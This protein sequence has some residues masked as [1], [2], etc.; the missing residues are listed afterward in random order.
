MCGG[1]WAAARRTHGVI[2]DALK[3]RSVLI[4][5]LSPLP[6]V[7]RDFV[8][9]PIATIGLW[10]HALASSWFPPKG[11]TARREAVRAGKLHPGIEIWFTRRALAESFAKDVHGAL[12]PR[13][14]WRLDE[15][16][17]TA[18]LGPALV[19]FA[20][21]GVSYPLTGIVVVDNGTKG[22]VTI[23]VDDAV[24]DVSPGAS[25]QLAVRRGMRHISWHG[26]GISGSIDYDVVRSRAALISPGP[27]RCYWLEI[28]VYKPLGETEVSQEEHAVLSESG[29]LPVV[30]FQT[31]PPPDLWFKQNPETRASG[32]GRR[33]SALLRDENCQR[34]LDRRCRPTTIV[35]FGRCERSAKDPA[36]RRSCAEAA[37][38]QCP[39]P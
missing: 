20:M 28:A 5:L 7:D 34:L 18:F 1:T 23:T 29:L 17:V 39:P 3:T 14:R 24:I 8:Y 10:L 25:D 16:V 26:D 11:A 27:A 22:V 37:L 13:R 4:V 33:N 12:Q 6:I 15:T 2:V 36:E 21:A 31:L 35:D 30:E 9:L 32:D 38:I 19:A